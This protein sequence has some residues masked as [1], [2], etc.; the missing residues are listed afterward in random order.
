MLT[1]NLNA[2]LIL[3][4]EDEESHC[5]L[6]RRSLD[7]AAEHYRALVVTTIQAGLAALVE[8]PALV[9]TDYRMP[10]GTGS[11]LVLSAKGRFPV[12][13]MT[14][15]GSE[16]IAVETLKIGAHDYIVKSPDMFE[17]L[18]RTINLALTSWA[19]LAARK[20]LADA[21]IN[22]KKDWERTFD[23]VPT[24]IAIINADHTIARVNKAMAERCGISAEEILGRKCYE[25][26]HDVHDAS[27]C[28][29]F[30]ELMKDGQI[31]TLEVEEKRLNGTFEITVSPLLDDE[32][33]M[34]SYVHVMRDISEKK[35]SAAAKERL[36]AELRQSQKL[37]S[38][39]RLA[40]GIAHDFNNLLTVILGHAE[41]ALMQ[42]EP[43]NALQK[44]L[45]EICRA[46]ERSAE[47]TRQL[48]AFARKQPISPRVI[49]LNDIVP[50]MLNM[51]KRLIGEDITLSWQPG[52]NLR[53]IR[54]D[55]T[56]VDQI[57][58]NLCVNARDAIADTGTI[59]IT[60]GNVTLKAG[61]AAADPDLSPGD[62]V[63]L[64]VDDTGFGMDAETQTHIFEPFFT[65]KEQGKGTG[66][67][68]A[69]VYGA[70]RQNSGGIVMESTPGKGTTFSLYFPCLAES[71]TTA[72]D[73]N[74]LLPMRGSETI[75]L[76][77]D[78]PAILKLA[79]TLLEKLGYTVLR[80]ETPE[81]AVSLAQQNPGSI[82]LLITD[83][84]MPEMNGRQLSSQILELQ[85]KAKLLFM[86]GY[87]ADVIARHG[88][89]ETG[90]H[91]LQKPFSVDSLAAAVRTALDS[92]GD[93]G[94][95]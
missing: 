79:A 75:L 26:V 74:H 15:H 34:T 43:G 83:V 10:D 91:F 28:C 5:E 42:S 23:A 44:D 92:T 58:V 84:I 19:L 71:E 87:T 8:N 69:M 72:P 94:S 40:G 39:G 78:D 11:E 65:T 81:A 45:Q 66:L 62:Y 22:A 86:S 85:P 54:I 53:Q 60:T 88:V 52:S 25:V 90:V 68:L 18:A 41:M 61:N 12:I 48:L 59:T 95:P 46:A 30:I 82:D 89:L 20:D 49:N 27:C 6:I 36:E 93:E 73:K 14:S 24:L 47:L 33:R 63:L 56:Q 7:D 16:Q 77:E 51:L 13:I 1:D 67:G 29:P 55:P 37:E 31:H 38:I 57:L 70:V 35:R 17:Q 9:L 32:G 80:A 64:R 2:P 50:K 3:I 76:G 4:V 21:A